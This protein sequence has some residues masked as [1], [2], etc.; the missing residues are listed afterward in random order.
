[1]ATK[2]NKKTE[3]EDNSNKP[4][5]SNYPALKNWLDRLDAHCM[6]QIPMNERPRGAGCDWAPTS[7]VECWM[8]GRRPIVILVHSNKMGWDIYTNA[9][10][11]RIDETLVDAE[12]RVGVAK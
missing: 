7:Y 11:S 10:T 1:M 4:W 8:V 3:S 6:W 9:D 5:V 2:S 12:R